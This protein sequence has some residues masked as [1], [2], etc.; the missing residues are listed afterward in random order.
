MARPHVALITTV[1]PAHL[2]AFENIEGIAYEKASIFEGLEP[3][4]VALLNAD[5]ATTPIL[6]EV[7]RRHAAR[8]LSFGWNRAAHHRLLS[9]DLHD[10]ATVARARAWRTPLLY[11][12]AV[13]GKHFALAALAVLA[14]V[15]VLR[16]DRA[17][18]M[19]DLANWSPPAGRGTRE[20]LVLDTGAD[21][22]SIDLI[23]DAFNA[24]PASMEA[25][26]DVLAA[27]HPRDDVGRVARGRRIAVLGDMLELGTTENALHAALAAL[28]AMQAVH[29]VHCVGPRMRALHAALP[30]DKRGR[31]VDRA[32]DLAREA[33][34]LVDAGDVVLV[35]GSKGSQ[36]SLIVTALRRAG[37][38]MEEDVA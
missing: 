5:V 20:R 25:A 9:V 6:R 30:R 17:V 13:P 23:D 22:M 26:L 29:E 4:G 21:G 36:V 27:S 8:I 32:E 31:R 1:A 33:H 3:G 11:K 19:A 38:K 34:R 28:P 15:R 2:E 18:A 35:K 12:I 10:D 7:A 14:V 24:N 16:L 37:R